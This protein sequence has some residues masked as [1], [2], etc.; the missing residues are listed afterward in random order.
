MH[1]DWEKLNKI[2]ELT[3]VSP[4]KD[5]GDP[6]KCDAWTET[7]EQTFRKNLKKKATDVWLKSAREII[8]K[9]TF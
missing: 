7:G 5:L 2:V 3:C 1:I 4:V 9:Q 6:S 8:N